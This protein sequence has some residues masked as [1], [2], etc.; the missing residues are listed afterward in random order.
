MITIIGGRKM[1]AVIT[2]FPATALASLRKT[3]RALVASLEVNTPQ[4]LNCV[5]PEPIHAARGMALGGKFPALM[6]TRV[7]PK[8]VCPLKFVSELG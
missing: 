1:F 5:C 2:A 4:A 6:V 3:L 8:I 7:A